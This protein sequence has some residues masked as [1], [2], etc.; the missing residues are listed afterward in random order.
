VHGIS[1]FKAR[2]KLSSEKNLV[3]WGS[4]P[5]PPIQATTTF[6]CVGIR[7]P[8]SHDSRGVEFTKSTQWQLPAFG[9]RNP[10]TQRYFWRS[11]HG[12]RERND[13]SGVRSTESV[14]ATRVLAFGPRNPWMQ[15]ECW[16][17]STESVD[18]TRVLA[19]G[20]RNIN[21]GQKCRILLRYKNTSNFVYA[22]F[23][24]GRP[25]ILKSKMGNKVARGHPKSRL[26]RKEWGCMST[27][28]ISWQIPLFFSNFSMAIHQEGQEV[29][30]SSS[31]ETLTC[32]RTTWLWLQGCPEHFW[33]RPGR[34]GDLH[35]FQNPWRHNVYPWL[36][37]L[38]VRR[39]YPLT[40]YQWFLALASS[41]TS[42][43]HL[44]W[45]KERSPA[46]PGISSGSCLGMVPG[47]ICIYIWK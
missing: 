31:I 14:N 3:L 16:R 47:C 44:R 15:R 7:D 35:V 36:F 19:F 24:I 13:T 43:K 30:F 10:W 33:S 46:N 5:R 38:L 29:I 42:H 39:V 2:N 34:L 6:H 25:G 41:V 1:M 26:P 40:G 23:K 20:P 37:Y 17:R 12:I 27:A 45:R 28:F 9:S 18:A 22:V 11:V 32:P 21:P 8:I 4:A